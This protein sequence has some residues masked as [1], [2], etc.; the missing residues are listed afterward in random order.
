M[1]QSNALGGQ[2]V[3]LNY[4]GT[5]A[6]TPPNLWQAKVNPTESTIAGYAI[7]DFWLNTET[8]SLFYLSSVAATSLSNGLQVATWVELNSG[9]V[10]PVFQITT[11]NGIATPVAGNLNLYGDTTATNGASVLFNASGSTITL[12][13]TDADGNTLI[14]D[15]C[16]NGTLTSLASTGVGILCMRS[17]TNGGGNTAFGA[18]SLRTLTTGGNNVSL[19][20]QSL[21]NLVSGGFN[22][23]IGTSAGSAYTGAESSNI[24]MGDNNQGTIGDSNT[25]RIGVGTGAGTGQL[26]RAFIQGISGINV[27][28]VAN[29]VSINTGTGQLGTTAITAGANITVTPGANTITIASTGGGLTWSV[30]TVNQ[31]AAINNGYICN[32]AGTLALALPAVSAVGSVIR[33]TGINTATGWQITQAAGQQIFFGTSSTTLGV[34]GTLT[35]FAIR[36]SIEIVCVV[37]NLTWNVISSIGNITIV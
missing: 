15:S 35:S 18:L 1:A 25:L 16:G 22:T 23:A 36:D 7:G 28:S 6:R 17:L 8:E 5:N 11:D 2:G 31:T 9:G 26:N 29:V 34:G 10:D 30:I 37:A 24:I 3:T 13:V 14:G 21:E 33:V 19:G 4:R 20:G 27:G 12:Q 32:K